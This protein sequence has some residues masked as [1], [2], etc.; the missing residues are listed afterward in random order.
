MPF[1][2]YKCTVCEHLFEEFLPKIPS[3]PPKANC[4][5]CDSEETVRYYGNDKTSFVLKGRGWA[6]DLYHA[7]KTSESSN[8]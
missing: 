1:Y 2:V 3:E 7:P 6:K 5:K 4:P 8:E